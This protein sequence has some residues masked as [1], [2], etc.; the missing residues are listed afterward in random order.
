MITSPPI[1]AVAD[2][3]ADVSIVARRMTRLVM[4]IIVAWL[5]ANLA[6]STARG[7]SRRAGSR[8][9]HSGGVVRMVDYVDAGGFEVG[10]GVDINCGCEGVCDCD[11][12]AHGGGAWEPGCGIGS[13][14]EHLGELDPNCGIEIG[15]PTL[16]GCGDGGPCESCD[17]F[18]GCDSCGGCDSAGGVGSVPVYLPFL[19]V[20]WRRFDFFAGVNGFVGPMNF[21]DVGNAELDGSG[22]FGFYEGFNEGRSLRSLLNWDMAAQLGVRFTQSNLSEASFAN[23]SRNQVFVTGG[24]FRRVDYGLQY[25]T[26]LDYLNDD[27]WFQ[28]DLLQSRSELSWKTRGPH[29][30][31]LTYMTGLNDDDSQTATTGDGGV[32]VLSTVGTEPVDQYRFFYRRLLAH[33]GQWEAFAGFTDDEDGLLGA[34]LDLPMRRRLVFSSSVAYLIPNE[35]PARRGFENESWNLSMGL[36]YRPGGPRGCG[37]YCRPLFNVADNGTFFV[38]RD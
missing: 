21:A 2:R 4:V 17:G 6:A 34:A 28:S 7:Q 19:K 5:M 20:D 31:G 15:S 16:G 25:G 8:G 30:F 35:G 29:V 3:F 24:L 10:C 12:G 33:S 14:I 18:G 1:E 23:E 37:R 36:I 13:A 27:W 32:E 22:S 11:P 26:V 38:R 9:Q